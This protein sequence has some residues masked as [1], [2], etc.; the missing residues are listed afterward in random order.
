MRRRAPR[1]GGASR[2]RVSRN[3]G[4]H[5]S[6]CGY[7]SVEHS[8]EH[9]HFS[10]GDKG[11]C[12]QAI[13]ICSTLKPGT[14]KCHTVESGGLRFVDKHGDAVTGNIVHLQSHSCPEGEPVL[15]RGRGVKRVRIILAEAEL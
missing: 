13:D 1:G 3:P 2:S 7:A 10:Y 5:P 14:L 4:S 11:R 12:L 9:Q 8:S 6:F 15:D